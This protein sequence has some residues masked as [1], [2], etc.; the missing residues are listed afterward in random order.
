MPDDSYRR[1]EQR[2]D[3]KRRNRMITSGVL[4]L[5]VA[6]AGGTG[7]VLACYFVA[8]GLTAQNAIGRI[9]HDLGASFVGGVFTDREIRGGGHNRVIGP[10][11]QW[12]PNQSDAVTGEVLYSQNVDQEGS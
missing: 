5:V 7:A 3:R 11:F 2:R 4:A 12:R 8:Q 9:R 1:L 10:D 6:A